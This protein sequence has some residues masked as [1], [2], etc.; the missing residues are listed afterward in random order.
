MILLSQYHFRI[1]FNLE[2]KFTC[3]TYLINEADKLSC[4]YPSFI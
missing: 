4:E 2:L 1:E 3:E